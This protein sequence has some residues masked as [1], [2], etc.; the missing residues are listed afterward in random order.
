MGITVIHHRDRVYPVSRQNTILGMFELTTSGIRD[1]HP[2]LVSDNEK[3]NIVLSAE[4][5]YFVICTEAAVDH[6]K[7]REFTSRLRADT[8]QF[9]QGN[10]ILAKSASE[11]PNKIMPLL[12]RIS[13]LSKFA[14]TKIKVN[15]YRT[16]PEKRLSDDFYFHTELFNIFAC[17]V[18]DL[19]TYIIRPESWSE[20]MLEE[21]LAPFGGL[22]CFD[23]RPFL[24]RE[25][26]PE[27]C[28][29]VGLP[30]AH[31]YLGS[32]K[33]FVLPTPIICNH[34]SFHALLSMHYT[35]GM[36]QPSSRFEKYRKGYFRDSENLSTL[37]KVKSLSRYIRSRW[38]G[39]VY[40]FSPFRL[41]KSLTASASVVHGQL[42]MNILELEGEQRDPVVS[43][44]KV[45]PSDDDKL[46]FRAEL[47]SITHCLSST[48]FLGC[49]ADLEKEVSSSGCTESLSVWEAC[50]NDSHRLSVMLNSSTTLSRDLTKL[51]QVGLGTHVTWKGSRRRGVKQLCGELHAAYCIL[52]NPKNLEQCLNHFFFGK[53]QQDQSTYLWELGSVIEYFYGKPNS[54]SKK[55]KARIDYYYQV[56]SI[57][58]H[59]SQPTDHGLFSHLYPHNCF[60]VL[61]CLYVQD[62]SFVRFRTLVDKYLL[63]LHS[64]FV[65]ESSTVQ[66]S[67]SSGIQ[68][69]G[70]STNQNLKSILMSCTGYRYSHKN[71][72]VFTSPGV[73]L[74]L[75]KDRG[76]TENLLEDLFLLCSEFPLYPGSEDLKIKVISLV[77][78]LSEVFM[79]LNGIVLVSRERYTL[80]V[81]QPYLDLDR[82]RK[83]L[84]IN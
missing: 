38:A 1:L 78:S 28:W 50:K 21:R 33:S 14:T 31:Q 22:H 64:I 58:A 59:Q 35:P 75:E 47:L 70:E 65:D 4:R 41:M 51:L 17:F 77:E 83:Q 62:R 8:I 56:Y 40:A 61:H 66:K 55:N 32:S 16:H 67:L 60:Q 34:G 81:V 13:H 68:V 25:I 52:K 53:M 6:S 24:F 37:Q 5:L 10:I 84:S 46:L 36:L 49:L 26:S 3:E 69:Q 9:I 29:K 15:E 72:T 27:D 82:W 71:C 19:C 57:E 20:D 18:D 7:G 42:L 39:L 73:P 54:L 76:S 63:V 74:D 79:Q 11:T 2:S 44:K 30:A 23:I 43:R 80:K 48:N 12:D 45:R